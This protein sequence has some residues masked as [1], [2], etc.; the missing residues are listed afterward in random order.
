MNDTVNLR[1]LH[2]NFVEGSL[3]GDVHLV[4]GGA[5][6]GE[7]LDA[8]DSDLGRIVQ[9]V[10]ND[11]IV[12]IVQ[13]REGGKRP[14]VAGTTASHTVNMMPCVFSSQERVEGE[15]GGALMHGTEVQLAKKKKKK[16]KETRQT[17][18]PVTSTVPTGIFSLLYGLTK[19]E[20]ANID[21]RNC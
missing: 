17:A 19:V 5:L 21:I 15:G 11:D 18:Y 10:D 2:E 13:Q 4:K 6:A 1:V 16:K 3:V 9:T 8:I 12:I 14:N 20:V 7:Q